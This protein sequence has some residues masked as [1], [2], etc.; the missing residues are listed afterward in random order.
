M[1][2]LTLLRHEHEALSALFSRYD[3]A[4]RD[5]QARGEACRAVRDR[6]RAHATLEEEVLYPAVLKVRA[7][8]ARA[9]VREAL[10]EN[11][12]LEGLLAA[13]DGLEPDEPEYARK[14]EVLRRHVER[15]TTDAEERVFRQARIHL[16]DARL[17]SLGRQAETSQAATLAQG[18]ERRGRQ[19]A[20]RASAGGGAPPRR[21]P[22][23]R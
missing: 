3:R 15:H 2:V 5:V 11:Q 8:G 6:L 20:C 9:V 18:T 21:V 16:T 14:V 13:L 10:N 7:Q 4:G 22:R 12:L 17:E 1:D 23:D 19:P